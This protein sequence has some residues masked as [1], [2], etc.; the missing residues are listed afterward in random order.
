MAPCV[1]RS[2]MVLVLFGASGTGKSAAAAEIGC[3]YGV[4]WVQVD[5]LRL[6]LQYSRV[7]L[8]ERTDELYFLEGSSGVWTRTPAELRQAFINVAELM[9]PALRTVIHSHVVTGAPMVIGGDG[10]SPA[11]AVDPLLKPLVDTGVIRFCCTATPDV[12]EVVAR[13]V[14]RRNTRRGDRSGVGPQR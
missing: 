13:A 8:P 10:V 2:W 9:A 12:E 3:R 4:S 7:T 14:F 6:T 11:L 1:S 5:D